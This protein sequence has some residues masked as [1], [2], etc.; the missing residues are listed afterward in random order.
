M[1]NILQSKMVEKL[2]RGET[3]ANF[4]FI[5]LYS[6]K[7]FFVKINGT[8]EKHFSNKKNGDFIG[9][10]NGCSMF[11]SDPCSTAQIHTSIYI[12]IFIQTLMHQAYR[13]LFQVTCAS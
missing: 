11:L 7:K 12:L 8:Q 10:T 4:S 1:Q 6:Y 2:L 5:Q 3:F 9:S 13:W